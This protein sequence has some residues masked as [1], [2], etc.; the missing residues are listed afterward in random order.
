MGTDI[1]LHQEV[2]ING[3]WHHYRHHSVA[4]SYRLFAIMAGVRN[5]DELEPIAQPK[6][7]PS[8]A[9]V[10]TLFDY[11]TYEDD[12]HHASWLSSSEIEAVFAW[13]FADAR[14]EAEDWFG[15]LFGNSWFT[16]GEHPKG[17]EDFRF[18]FWFGS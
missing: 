15:Y 11:E 5:R 3:A 12:S 2:K 10:L 7:V 8:D 18:V 13:F 4:R 9:T 17:L 16:A 1:Y 6:G 14:H